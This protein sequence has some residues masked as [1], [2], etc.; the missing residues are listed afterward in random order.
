M[1]VVH[2]AGSNVFVYVH[3]AYKGEFCGLC[4]NYN[5]DASDDLRLI[6]GK[7]AKDEKSFHD[8]WRR[9][10]LTAEQE[11]KFEVSPFFPRFLSAAHA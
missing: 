11:E 10:S 1:D 7:L 6:D 2:D 4:G 5:G 8:G 3:K 9:P